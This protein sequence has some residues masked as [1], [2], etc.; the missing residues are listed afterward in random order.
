MLQS[1]AES[2]G[3]RAGLPVGSQTESVERGGGIG[4]V[5]VDSTTSLDSTSLPFTFGSLVLP[6][7]LP[8][9]L[10]SLGIGL[11]IPL[12]PLYAQTFDGSG[13]LAGIIVGLFGFGS[14]CMNVPSGILSARLGDRNAIILSVVMHVLGALGAVFAANPFMLG[15]A[16]FILGAAR[17]LFFV[18]R[19][20]YFRSLV[21][22]K[23]RGRALAIIGGEY[24]LGNALGPV[25]GGL[26]AAHVDYPATF[27]GL[28]LITLMV[29]GMLV[30]WAP[31]PG[32]GLAG[33]RRVP[34]EAAEA[35]RPPVPSMKE[36]FSGAFRAFR[37]NGRIFGTA[38]LAVV[39]LQF[40]RAGRSVVLPLWGNAI[41]LPVEQVGL[42]VGIM[43]GVEMIMFIPAGYVMDRFGRKWAGVP[44]L[45]LLAASMILLM[46]SQSF[47]VYVAVAVVA[48][49]GNGMAS[50]LNMTLSTD[51]AP[52]ANASNFIGAWRFI[53]DA[54]TTGGPFIVGAARAAGGLSWTG[55]VVAVFGLVGAAVMGILVKEPKRSG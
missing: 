20:S 17:S 4:G 14:L 8:E 16:V 3:E 2:A 24:R 44:S 13:G 7:Y 48:G 43:F 35:E 28:G 27:A 39:M 9:F 19:L 50:G 38:G 52:K 12:L 42:T 54:G 22:R 36:L 29:L 45:S 30:R 34:P 49:I 40:V 37:G 1:I 23:F 11:A 46:Y 47:A 26:L 53:A 15:T 21:P 5:P 25:A 41:G 31:R 55:G 10:I 33:R 51:Y 32:Q 18:S 6:F